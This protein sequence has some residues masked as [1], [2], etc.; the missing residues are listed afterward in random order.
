M[1][2]DGSA[3]FFGQRAVSPEKNLDYTEL[4]G[5]LR[6]HAGSGSPARNAL[7]FTAADE[8]NEKQIKFHDMI[9]NM[10]WTVHQ[11][12][13]HEATVGNPLLSD[14]QARIIRFDAMI[15]Y[16]MGRLTA[17]FQ[18]VSHLVVISDSWPICAPAR[19]CALRGKQ[20]TIAFF[21]SVIDTRWHKAFREAE[22]HNEQLKFLD[23][24][25]VHAKLFSRSRSVPRRQSR[26]L[27][28]P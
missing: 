27:D 17:G 18:S 6:L 4:D 22:S 28:L 14:Q 8:S 15:T 21:G 23:L 24:D 13:P 16:A 19:D 3:L 12:P 1:L 2:V 7:F 5:L 26:L 9:S 25:A 10:G 20:V 11:V